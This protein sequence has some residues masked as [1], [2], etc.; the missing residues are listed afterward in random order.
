MGHNII[1]IYMWICVSWYWAR[2]PLRIQW[3][4]YKLIDGWRR[5]P[6]CLNN[7]LSI[8]IWNVI[9]GMSYKLWYSMF[10]TSPHIV[11]RV[12]MAMIAGVMPMA[13]AWFPGSPVCY[14]WNEPMYIIFGYEPA[15]LQSILYK[16]PNALC[17]PMKLIACSVPTDTAPF[18][19]SLVCYIQK[20]IMYIIFGYELTLLQSISY[21]SPNVPC[22]P[23]EL[24]AR[25]V[26]TD[27]ALFLGSPVCYV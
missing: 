9:S 12:P 11:P 3:I 23:M 13:M 1:L 14:I 7:I 6:L 4:N 15:V 10:C 18:S 17:V 8:C 22:V 25:S 2:N 27:T 24:I 21:R 20:K 26:P 19:G 16:S 5:H